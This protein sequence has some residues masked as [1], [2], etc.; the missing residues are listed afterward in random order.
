[1][2][3]LRTQI[4]ELADIKAEMSKLKER[5]DKLEAEIIKHTSYGIRIEFVF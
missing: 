1:M 2:T 3:D 5:K 4:D